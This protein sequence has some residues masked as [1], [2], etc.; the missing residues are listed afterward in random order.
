M[1]YLSSIHRA[2]HGEHPGSQ[3]NPNGSPRASA[4]VAV[5]PGGVQAGA[6]WATAVAKVNSR[7]SAA[8]SR[9]D[10]VDAGEDRDGSKGS[11]TAASWG[12]AVSA[13]NARLQGRGVLSMSAARDAVEAD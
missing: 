9:S 3:S 12:A 4:V 7:V 5:T 1:S 2:V 10:A 8:A 6:S 11:R 13:C